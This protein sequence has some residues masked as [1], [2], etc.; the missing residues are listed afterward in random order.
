MTKRNKKNHCFKFLISSDSIRFGVSF[1]SNIYDL[2]GI[3][4]I[5]PSF[6]NNLVTNF[7]TTKIPKFVIQTSTDFYFFQYQ[8]VTIIFIYLFCFCSSIAIIIIILDIIFQEFVN[9]NKKWYWY[10]RKVLFCIFLVNYPSGYLIKNT[11]NNVTQCIINILQ[12]FVQV[13]W[14]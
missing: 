1:Y 4:Q 14:I 2:V 7:N 6:R 12:S 11:K 13:Y 10:H 5:F 8:H 3:G 9:T